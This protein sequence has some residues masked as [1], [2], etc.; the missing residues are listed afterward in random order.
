MSSYVNTDD[1]SVADATD[2][3]AEA[4]GDRDDEDEGDEREE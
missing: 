1:L 3:A 2:G 4:D